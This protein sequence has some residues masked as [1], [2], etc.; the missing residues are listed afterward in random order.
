MEIRIAECRVKEK[1]V[2]G[3]LLVYSLAIY[4]ALAAVSFTLL[5]DQKWKYRLIWIASLVCYPFLIY[6]I[7]KCISLTYR[8]WLNN[9]RK[10]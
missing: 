8:R 10:L 3:G 9:D 1:R 6:M 7:K 2:V 4:L 5:R